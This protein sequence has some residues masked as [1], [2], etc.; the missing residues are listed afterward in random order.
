MNEILSD[1]SLDVIFREARSLG[2]WLDKPVTPVT[3]QAVYDLARL[4][5]TAFNGC[6]ARFVFVTSAEGKE[7]L[8][9]TL[10]PGNVEKVMTAP[11]TVI[12]GYDLEYYREL[13]QLLPHYEG[14][15]ERIAANPDAIEPGAFRNGSL[16]AAYLI[17]A[18]RALGLDCGPMSG[19]DNAAVDKAFFPGGRIKSNLI[20]AMGYGD[21]KALRP[22]SPRLSFDEAC[23]IV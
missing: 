13:P 9:P 7:R 1:K 11:V 16:Q 8:K 4:G 18:A 15:A 19:F 10:M 21:R 22:R 6:P 12:I 17:I 2:A 20:C 23:Q 3:L 14:L 5:P